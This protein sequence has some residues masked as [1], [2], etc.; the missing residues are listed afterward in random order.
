MPGLPPRIITLRFEPL[1]SEARDFLSAAVELFHDGDFC[2]ER[3][4]VLISPNFG[5]S[6]LAR[7]SLSLPYVVIT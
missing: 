7:H 2:D 3:V 6:A 5:A 1:A 4:A